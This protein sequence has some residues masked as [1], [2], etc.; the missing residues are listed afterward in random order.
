MKWDNSLTS[1]EFVREIFYALSNDDSFR[2]FRLASDGIDAGSEVLDQHGFSK[3]RYYLR[4]RQLIHL[5]LVRKD[6][7]RYVHTNLGRLVHE[8]TKQL[9]FQLSGQSHA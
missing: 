5:G 7:G 3:K 6:S 8:S 4:L 2:I 9:E 1:E